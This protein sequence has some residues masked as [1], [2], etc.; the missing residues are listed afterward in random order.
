VVAHERTPF[1]ERALRD[2]RLDAI[3]AQNPGHAVRSALR[4]LRAR[5]DKRQLISTQEK[6]RIEILLA[7]NL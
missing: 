2:E 5:R 7:E 4:I 3:I 1:N 6:I